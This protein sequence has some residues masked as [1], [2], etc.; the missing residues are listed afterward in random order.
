ML[1]QLYLSREVKVYV[2]ISSK[3][4]IEFSA[5]QYWK[6]VNRVIVI[7]LVTLTQ[8]MGYISMLARTS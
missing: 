7:R 4:P 1:D 5:G 6:Y 8:E 2:S 3:N